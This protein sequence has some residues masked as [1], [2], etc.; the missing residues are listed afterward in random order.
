MHP[1]MEPHMSLAHSEHHEWLRKQRQQLLDFYQ[2][3]VCREEGGMAWLSESGEP[4]ASKGAQLWLGARMIH[5]FAL[6]HLNGRQGAAEVVEHGLDFYCGGPG[7]D[8]EYG[9]WFPVVGGDSP[10][11]QKELYGIAHMLLAGSSATVAGFTRGPELMD[12]A[13]RV[14]DSHFWQESE[15][16]CVEAYDRQFSVLDSYRGQNANMHLTEAYIAAYE[17]TGNKTLL[18]RATSIARFIA[19][20]AVLDTESPAPWRLPEHFTPD[21]E[22]IPDYNRDDPRHP[23]RPYGTQVGHWLEWSKLCMQLWGLEVDEAWLLPTAETLFHHAVAEGWH[24]DGGFSYTLDWDGNPVVPE[25]YFWPPAEAIGAAK[26]LH[27]AT[28][29]QKYLDWYQRFWEFVNNRLTDHDRGGWYHEI[30]ADGTPARHT[31]EGKPD[32]YHAYQATLYAEVPTGYGLAT[33]LR[34]EP[35]GNRGQV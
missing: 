34:D 22:P 16:R 2:P 32:L 10:E 28:G 4:I 30:G 26:L 20:R 31:W 3:E 19:G 18:D 33:C 1:A 35:T 27:D 8:R 12:E 23:F 7:S 14:I 5:V 11:D 13:L 29:D 25:R 21:W 9:G 24:A 17:A 6:A 15:G